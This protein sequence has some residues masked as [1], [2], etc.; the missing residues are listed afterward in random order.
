METSKYHSENTSATYGKARN[1]VTKENSYIG[2]C[3]H[4]SESTDVGFTL[5][6]GH[7]GP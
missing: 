3:T 7:E 2:H 6:I 5:F 1:Q 4:T